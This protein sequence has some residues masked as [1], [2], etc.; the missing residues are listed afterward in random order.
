MV[1][2]SDYCGFKIEVVA[3]HVEGA[4]D[5]KIR[6][7]RILP[8][9]TACAGLLTCRKPIAQVAEERGAACARQLDRSAL[10]LVMPHA[11]AVRASHHQ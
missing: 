9:V 2:E 10:A 5:A 11:P 1:I 7:S 4:W 3:V 6:I 8:A